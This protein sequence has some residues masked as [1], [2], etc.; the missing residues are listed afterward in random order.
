MKIS[1]ENGAYLNEYKPE[2][3]FL[4]VAGNRY[5]VEE[6]WVEKAH[7]GENF[8]DVFTGDLC[9]VVKFKFEQQDTIDLHSYVK[10]DGNG[11]ARIWVNLSNEEYGKDTLAV[12]Y[13]QTLDSLKKSQ[14]FLLFKKK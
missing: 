12:L 4:I 6:A 3:P 11:I 2:F 5:Y 1:K 7:Q 14:K 8:R 9:L 13:R 10:E